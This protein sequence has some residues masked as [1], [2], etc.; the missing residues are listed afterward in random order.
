M[1][2]FVCFGKFD[3]AIVHDLFKKFLRNLDANKLV[4]NLLLI[5]KRRCPLALE[6]FL[7]I[8]RSSFSK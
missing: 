7:T 5:D 4:C 3:E 2:Y 8:L 6:A 1:E